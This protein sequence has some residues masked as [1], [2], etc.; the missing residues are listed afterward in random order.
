MQ[1]AD[2]SL[3]M[4]NSFFIEKNSSLK[5]H[6]IDYPKMLYGKGFQMIAPTI[7]E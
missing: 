7:F 4:P 5:R 3:A 2:C 1:I 6:S